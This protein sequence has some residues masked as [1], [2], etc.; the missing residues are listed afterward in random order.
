VAVC[1][2]EDI[3]PKTLSNIKEVKSRGAHIIAL[4]KDR[5]REHFDED[6][7]LI[8]VDGKISDDLSLISGAVALQLLSYHTAVKRGCE[9]DKP[10]NLAKSVTVE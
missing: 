3:L 6:D 8:T 4:I 10:R 9:V 7:T 5:F 2:R 1:L